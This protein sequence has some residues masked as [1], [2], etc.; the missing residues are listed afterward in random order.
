MDAMGCR[1]KVACTWTEH[2]KQ[3]LLAWAQDNI[4]YVQVPEDDRAAYVDRGQLYDGPAAMCL[5]RWGFWTERLEE[6]AKEE[7]GL[8]EGVRNKAREKVVDIK[9][10]PRK[11][12]SINY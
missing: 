5:R 12:L 8:D 3:P 9:K 6:L 1:V 7:L 11:H 4:S 10:N 2:G